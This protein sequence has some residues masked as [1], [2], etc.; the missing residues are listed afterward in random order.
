M[1]RIISI[2]MTVFLISMLCVFAEAEEGEVSINMSAIKLMVTGYEI[3]NG[4]VTP[5]EN[6]KITV[7]I[8]NTN[9]Y[10]SA[11]N[12]KLTLRDGENELVPKGMGSL[13]LPYIS[14]GGTYVW[15]TSLS[16][17]CTA[18]E[19]R[20]TLSFTAEYEDSNY[21][22][23]S[24]TDDIFVDVR[25]P[26]SL[27]I[28]GVQLPVKSVQG[29]TVS[30]TLTFS[31]SGRAEI[32]NIKVSADVKGLESGGVTFV[33]S[34]LPGENT[35]ATINLRVSKEMLGDTEGKIKISYEDVY[36]EKHSQKFNVTTLIE[37]KIEL[38]DITPE[39]EQAKYPLWWAFLLGGL[40]IGGGIGC[41][42]PIG[43]YSSKQRKEDEKRL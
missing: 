39:E 42:V 31:N 30:S 15:E 41:A 7:T 19:G 43:V 34:V 37:E 14:Y 20:H 17:V 35:S 24:S 28:S 29:E 8:K 1:K 40:A 5:G 13:Y 22:S 11:K 3:E 18:R 9:A 4:F 32:R 23:Y 21:S 25:Q 10:K 36:G 6:A 2:I 33:G 16:A 27:D 12:I 38:T 26:L